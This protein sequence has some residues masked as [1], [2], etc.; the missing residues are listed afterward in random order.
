MLRVCQLV[1]KKLSLS[2]VRLGWTVGCRRNIASAKFLCNLSETAP[3][4]SYASTNRME[5]SAHIASR[6]WVVELG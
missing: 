6:E 4:A 2:G 1:S 5:S 3:R